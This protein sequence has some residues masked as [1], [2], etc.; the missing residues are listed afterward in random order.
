MPEMNG[1]DLA[2]EI[3]QLN[4]QLPVVIATGFADLQPLTTLSFPRLGKPYTQDQLA[5]FLESAVGPAAG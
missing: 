5:A 4:P 2:K 3:K 1:L